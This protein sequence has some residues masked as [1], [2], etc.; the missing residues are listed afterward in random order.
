MK[1]FFIFRLLILLAAFS[2]SSTL[3]AA[4]TVDGSQDSYLLGNHIEY[5]EE[6]GSV[7]SLEEI[8]SAQQNFRFEQAKG[9]VP[10]FGQVNSAFWFKINVNH[11]LSEKKHWLI[12]LDS[13]ILIISNFIP[14]ISMDAITKLSPVIPTLFLSV[15]LKHIILF[16]MSTF[17]R[18]N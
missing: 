17:L 10:N 8:M 4:I 15:Q 1:Y 12:E 5:L 7:L 16:L 18:N 11:Q 9:P 13:P 14:P 6:K 2:I 3:Y